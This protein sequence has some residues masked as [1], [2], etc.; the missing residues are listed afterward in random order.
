MEC[1]ATL[2]LISSSYSVVSSNACSL[3]EPAGRYQ[4]SQSV[5]PESSEGSKMLEL[6]E[7]SRIAGL[8]VIKALTDES[9]GDDNGLGYST[10]LLKIYTRTGI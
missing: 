7:R 4:K 6:A 10:P 1:A 2:L 9:D 3:Q 8:G 5:D